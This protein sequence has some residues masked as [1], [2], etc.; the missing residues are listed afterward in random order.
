MMMRDKPF[1]LVKTRDI[2][3]HGGDEFET[4]GWA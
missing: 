3:A 1:S 2:S 4:F